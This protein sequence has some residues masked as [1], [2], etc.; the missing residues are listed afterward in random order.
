MRLWRAYMAANIKS[1]NVIDPEVKIIEL[2]EGLWIERPGWVCY[3]EGN[4]DKEEPREIQ[5]AVAFK[6]T[7]LLEA[8]ALEE[9]LLEAGKSWLV[10]SQIYPCPE[11]LSEKFVKSIG[12]EPGAEREILIYSLLNHIGGIPFDSQ[13]VQPA[14]AK[15]TFSTKISGIAMPAGIIMPYFETEEEALAFCRERIEILPAIFGLIGFYL[16]NPVNRIGNTGW[17]QIYEM[18]LDK[19]LISQA[20]DRMKEREAT[21]I[22]GF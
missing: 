14:R 22:R 3:I 19:D 7:D 11:E 4:A 15:G 1:A 2:P 12:A 17:D 10:E 9:D 8:G 5:L 20:I 13:S 6:I 18:V 16:D 21:T